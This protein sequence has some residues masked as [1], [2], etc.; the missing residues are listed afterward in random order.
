VPPWL[1]ALADP[2]PFDPA[3]LLRVLGTH[4]VDYVLIGGLA[5][6]LYG[7]PHVT[8]DVDIT[9]AGSRENL[10]RLAKALDD[11]EARI[12]VEGEPAGVEFDRSAEM[13]SRTSLLNLTTRAGDLD[14]AFAPHGTQGYP[15]LRKRAV[16]L[17]IDG[18][19]VVVA[20]LADVIRSKEAAGREKDRL[21]L[22]TLRRLL[23]RR[24]DL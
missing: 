15:D 20:D 22:P 14:L 2:A 23:E 6:T 8:T 21:T 19:T 16:E 7:S 11:L 17:D 18:V 3:E 4:G 13:L 1:S 5:A 9:P 24:S 10:R 12:R